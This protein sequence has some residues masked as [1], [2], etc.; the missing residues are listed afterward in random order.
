MLHGEKKKKVLF[1][2]APSPQ[3]A[4]VPLQH[5]FLL[6]L[7]LQYMKANL[8]GLFLSQHHTVLHTRTLERE[9]MDHD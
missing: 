1:L 3:K 4:L 9:D 2:N 5:F 7:S 6:H 8:T